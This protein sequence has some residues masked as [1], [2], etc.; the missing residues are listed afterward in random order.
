MDQDI[1]IRPFNIYRDDMNEHSIQKG[2]DAGRI[3]PDDA[4]RIREFIGVTR[5]EGLS[6]GRIRSL[7]S[8]LVNIRRYIPQ[9]TGITYPQLMAGV[10]SMRGG[11]YAQTTLQE[12]LKILK[13]FIRFLMEYGYTDITEIQLKKIKISNKIDKALTPADILTK[14]EIL[15]LVGACKSPRDRALI[16]LTYESGARISE[17]CELRWK[18]ITLLEDGISITTREGKKGER[19]RYIRVVWCR[20]YVAEWKN[21]YPVRLPS[22]DHPI[23]VTAQ[24]KT[25]RYGVLRTQFNAIL[26]RSG[27]EKRT[28]LHSLRHARATHLLSDGYSESAIKL[29]LWG[30]IDTRMLT[31]YAHLNNADIDREVLIKHGL[32]AADAS[33][34]PLA[35]QQCQ[36]C[37]LV[38]LPGAMYCNRCGAPLTKSAK[39]SVDTAMSIGKD[40]P[41]YRALLKNIKEDL[42]LTSPHLETGPQ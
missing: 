6:A 3:T 34:D 35:P 41:E 30:S 39:Q 9:Y 28:T 32:L 13:K 7:C 14:D 22:P 26:K 31:T 19:R 25:L 5:G 23:F 27:I 16:S 33:P 40:S 37:Y 18:D 24:G 11:H 4:A 20:P 15:S 29:M 10:G 38:N 12:S 21:A 17:V 42:G 8:K 36:Q 2:L 1:D